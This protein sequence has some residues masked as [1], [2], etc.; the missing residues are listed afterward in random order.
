MMKKVIMY[1][2]NLKILSQI[3]KCN[4]HLECKKMLQK[5]RVI[6]ERMRYSQTNE[7]SRSGSKGKYF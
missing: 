5:Q 7:K 4:N 3:W 2:N 6:K 1:T